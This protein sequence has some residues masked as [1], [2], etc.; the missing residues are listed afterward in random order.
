MVGQALL[1]S[2]PNIWIHV[3]RVHDLDVSD[4]VGE[5]FEGAADSG[6][7]AAEALAAVSGDED[8]AALERNDGERT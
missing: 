1:H 2:G 7:A 6:Q 4:L 8:D 5:L 3:Y